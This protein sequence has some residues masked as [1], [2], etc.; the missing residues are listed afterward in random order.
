MIPPRLF[1]FIRHGRT[2]ANAKGLMCGGEWDVDLNDEGRQQAT[3]VSELLLRL[4]CKIDKIFVSPMK[5]A[6]QTAALINGHSKLPLC[7]VEELR[8]WC[9]GNWESKPWG[10]VP[11]PFN[12]T[13][14]PPQGEPRTIFERRI[15][16]AVESVLTEFSGVPLFVSHGA[17]AHALFTVLGADKLQIEN[18]TLYRIEPAGLKWLVTKITCP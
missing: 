13:E 16:Q 7:T 15:E 3:A 17:A 9:V 8:E 11:N 14:E 5:R 18:C 2:D 10:E 6:Q 1:Y 4:D 12:T